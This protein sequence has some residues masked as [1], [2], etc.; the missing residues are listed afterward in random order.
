MT[1]PLTGFPAQPR[2]DLMARLIADLRT[3]A[4][5]ARQEAVTGRLADPAGA[6]GGRVAEALGLEQALAATAQYRE[7]IDLAETRAGITQASLAALRGIAVDLQGRGQTALDTP[8]AA[9]RQAVSAEARAALGAAVSAL[10]A[11]FG[12]RSLFAGDGGPGAVVAAESV[13]SAS[14][15]ILE[16]GPTGG[17]AYANLTV[18]FTVA[19][20]LYDTSLYT[21]GVGD[22]PAAEVAQ[23]ERLS[24]S[25]RADEVPVRHLL[26]DLAALAAAFDP[27]N[28]IAADAREEI[29][30][31]AID[32][33]RGNVE[34]LTGIAARI[35]AAQARMAEAK[36]GHLAAE[37]SLTVA[38]NKLTGRDQSEAAIELT[39]L[40]TQLETSYIAT[41]RIASLSLAN[42]LR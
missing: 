27:G 17:G 8:L 19:G 24:L 25:A 30:R 12:G 22:A 41:A 42:F 6:L 35:G 9:A 20:A 10:N 28:A 29:A 21:G 23:G 15:A 32:G 13:F 26:R 16:A 4:D 14:L 33:L 18:E 34:G 7:I 1:F 31:Q 38:L 11:S 3:R 36:A 40:E 5:T 39:A 2:S 37:T